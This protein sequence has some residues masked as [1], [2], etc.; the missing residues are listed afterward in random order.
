MLQRAQSVAEGRPESPPHRPHPG[1]PLYPVA[2][3][4]WSP[5]GPADQL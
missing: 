1:R 4:R 2:S 3:P 5:A